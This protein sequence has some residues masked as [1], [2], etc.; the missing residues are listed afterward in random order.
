MRTVTSFR[1]SPTGGQVQ[2]TRRAYTSDWQ[3]PRASE[4]VCALMVDID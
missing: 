2:D 4:L 1:V 3:P